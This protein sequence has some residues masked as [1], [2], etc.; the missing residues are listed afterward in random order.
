MKSGIIQSYHTERLRHVEGV[1]HMYKPTQNHLHLCSFTGF[2][3]LLAP[4]FGF[5]AHFLSGSV[6]AAHCS[7]TAADTVKDQM[8]K[9]VTPEDFWIQPRLRD[10][11]FTN[12]IKNGFI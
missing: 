4:S 7:Q 6:S 1:T 10:I 3:P 9:P 5:A 12:W 2:E 11:M 8:L